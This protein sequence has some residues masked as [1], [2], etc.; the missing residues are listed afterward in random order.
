MRIYGV[1]ACIGAI[2]LSLSTVSMA[3]NQWGNYRGV[4]RPKAPSRPPQWNRPPPPP[5]GHRPP[6]NWG[7]Q[8]PEYPQRPRHGS[9]IEY[10]YQPNTQYEYRTERYVFV[11]GNTLPIEYR[12]DQYYINDWSGH[13]LYDPPWGTRWYS[14][15]GHYLLISDDSFR[16]EVVR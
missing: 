3:E 13:Q 15:G 1:Y 9:Y 16:I 4:E 11:R 7:G 12:N 14:V 5:H 8:Y 2:L 6:H 10:H